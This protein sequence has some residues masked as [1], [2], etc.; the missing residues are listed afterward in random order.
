M[1]VTANTGEEE[2]EVVRLS[3]AEVK[4]YETRFTQ[5]VVRFSSLQINESIGKGIV[6]VTC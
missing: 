1:S 4:K 3:A 2:E 6:A 5:S